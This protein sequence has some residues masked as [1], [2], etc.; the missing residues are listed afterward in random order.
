MEKVQPS[1]FL[2]LDSIRGLAALAVLF[3]HCYNLL[4]DRFQHVSL[5]H[6]FS[7]LLD[8]SLLFKFTPLR[9]LINGRAAVIIFFVLSGFVLRPSFLRARGE[10]YG[11]YLGQRLVRLW[12]P[13]VAAILVASGLLWVI[14]AHPIPQVNP[15][16]TRL[17]WQ[18]RAGWPQILGALLASGRAGDLL[19]DMPLWSLVHELRISLLFPLIA[20]FVSRRPLVWLAA[21]TVLRFICY[22]LSPDFDSAT[23]GDSL[24]QTGCFVM[25]FVLGF[26]LAGDL[27]RIRALTARAGTWGC[28]AALA[29]ALLMFAA[30]QSSAISDLLYAFGAAVVIALTASQPWVGEA[31]LFKPIAWLGRVS[32]SLYLIHLV[33][34]TAI[35][36]LVYVNL[37]WSPHPV[38]L[39]AVILTAP[40][41]AAEIFH[42]LVEA[43]ARDLSHRV[44]GR[45][46]VVAGVG[47]NGRAADLDPPLGQEPL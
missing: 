27:D 9:M 38:V 44:Y 43:P 24:L 20:V 47:A 15:D 42:R 10:R 31:L 33:V 41:I 26:V 46:A 7:A 35:V 4:P 28:G 1:R 3:N 45:L 17:V 23:L 5:P 21:A 16:F 29:L 11:P 32:F 30:P 8:P 19:M 25:F 39:G 14:G 6:H 34:V 36:H 18:T 22:R 13:C 40:L 37:G 12:I 2:G